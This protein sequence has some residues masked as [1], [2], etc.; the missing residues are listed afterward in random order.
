AKFDINVIVIPRKEQ[1]TGSGQEVFD[2][3]ITL[4][5]EYNTDLFERQTAERMVAHY[6]KVLESMV[7]N[8]ELPLSK[9]PL[10][11]QAERQHLLVTR[12]E[13]HTQYSEDPSILQ[14]FEAQA[15]RTPDS[16]A[17]SFEDACLTY[18]AL[19][20]RTAQLARYLASQ[21]IGPEALI[22]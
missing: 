22:G 19:E 6:L 4:V 1:L 18:S 13:T 8:L 14:L 9:I 15:L 5:W 20:K 11:T 7:E 17:V 21:G 12:N 3:D 2:D 10:L 16:V